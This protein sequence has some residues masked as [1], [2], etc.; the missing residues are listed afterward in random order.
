MYFGEVYSHCLCYISKGRGKV[1]INGQLFPIDTGSLF[2]FLPGIEIEAS[3]DEE[4]LPLEF[5]IVKFY[6]AIA[7]YEEEWIFERLTHSKFPI[8]GQVIVQNKAHILTLFINMK[9]AA[10]RQGKIGSIKLKALFNEL[11]YD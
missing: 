4:D 1:D 2:I 5:Y 6:F 3:S 9:K 7:Y 10:N 11:I 8:E